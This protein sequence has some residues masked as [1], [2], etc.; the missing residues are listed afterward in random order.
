[1]PIV[2]AVRIKLFDLSVENIENVNTTLIPVIP[3][4]QYI[5]ESNWAEGQNPGIGDV[6][7]GKLPAAFTPAVIDNGPPDNF[8]ELFD[9]MRA[10]REDAL[11]IEAD[12]KALIGQP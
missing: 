12:F 11:Q 8:A 4:F 7:D 9:R 2:R 10:N 3:G 5:L 1:M 6:W